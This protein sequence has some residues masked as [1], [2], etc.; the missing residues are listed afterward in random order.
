MRTLCWRQQANASKR[1]NSF[2]SLYVLRAALRAPFPW[3]SGS[4]W[5]PKH[6]VTLDKPRR[7]RQHVATQ[8]FTEPGVFLFARSPATL[9]LTTKH[10]D[11][12]A[13][14]E[15]KRFTDFASSIGSA[16]YQSGLSIDTWQFPGGADAGPDLVG[17]GTGPL[18]P[19]LAAGPGTRPPRNLGGPVR[20]TV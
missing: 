11:F 6:P 2:L 1:P 3:L 19:A 4:S 8:G 9:L 20:R 12:Y 15:P 7:I 16:E 14:S 10:P 13:W 18:Y 5:A 17:E